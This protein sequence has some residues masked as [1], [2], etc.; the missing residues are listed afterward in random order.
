MPI[1]YRE[2]LRILNDFDYKKL[3]QKGSHERWYCK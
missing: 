1:N 2:L 3:H